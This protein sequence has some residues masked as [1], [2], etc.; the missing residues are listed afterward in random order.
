MHRPSE[1][2][3]MERQ[4]AIGVPWTAPLLIGLRRRWLAGP[5]SPERKRTLKRLAPRQSSSPLGCVL[6]G[7]CCLAA[8]SAS[9]SSLGSASTALILRP[10]ASSA[11]QSRMPRP[12]CPAWPEPSR[13]ERSCSCSAA[14]GFRAFATTISRLAAG[15]GPCP[16]I[17]GLRVRRPASWVWVPSARRSHDA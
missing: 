12:R 4:I 9:S 8:G 5:F 3:I 6:G 14:H 2:S 10:H 15:A 17:W 7:T 1:G 11:S 13:K 16:S